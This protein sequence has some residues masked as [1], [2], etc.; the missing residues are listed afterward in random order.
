MLLL[1]LYKM[2]ISFVLVILKVVME[3]QT[4]SIGM[5]DDASIISTAVVML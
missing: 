4:R 1:M 3:S 5:L 2:T